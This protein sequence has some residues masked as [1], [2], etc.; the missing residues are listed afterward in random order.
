[1]TDSVDGDRRPDDTPVLTVT[2]RNVVGAQVVVGKGNLAIQLTVDGSSGYSDRGASAP[3][4][5][6]ALPVLR[7]RDGVDEPV[8]R[9][10]LIDRTVAELSGGRSVQLCGAPGTGK[11]AVAEAVARRLGAD[12][13]IGA[14]V[15]GSRPGRTLDSL[16]FSLVRLFFDVKWYEPDEAI[17]RAETARAR[18][19]G[20]IVVPD[21]E[22]PAEDAERLLG[23]FPDCTFLLTSRQQSLFTGATV[24]DLDPL[25]LDTARQL[26]EHRS[27]GPLRGLRTRRSNGPT[28]SAKGRF[29]GSWSAPHSSRGSLRTRGRP[30]SFRCLPKSRSIY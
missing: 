5:A 24:F 17:L 14:L 29:P 6:R 7:L 18:L 20:V 19:S 25:G 22:L 10:S 23:T 16:Y 3:L 28:S 8:G 12:R 9:T 27:V 21:C 30:L 1:M 15:T 4:Q 2:I 13:R 11:A 26:V